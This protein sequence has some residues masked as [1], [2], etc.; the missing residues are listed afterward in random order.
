MIISLLGKK[1]L[2]IQG[3]LF[4]PR[5]VVLAIVPFTESPWLPVL[6]DTLFILVLQVI[7][8]LRN[9]L[10]FSWHSVSPQH[11]LQQLI[12]YITVGSLL[13]VRKINLK[14]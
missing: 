6:Q 9:P 12:V 1:I 11:I 3:R 14:P 10:I 8:S 5:V 13:V 4:E 2:L 7:I